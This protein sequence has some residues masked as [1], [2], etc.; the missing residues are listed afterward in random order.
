MRVDNY[1]WLR[2]KTN[3]EVIAY[4]KA[5][6]DYTQ[7]VLDSMKGFQET[8]Y[9]DMLSRIKETDENVPYRKGDYWYYS[10]TETGKQYSIYCRKKGALDSPEEVI[11]DLNELA[12]GHSFLGLSAFAVSPNGKIWRIRSTSPV[13]G[14]TRCSSRILRPARRS[15]TDTN[16]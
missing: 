12:R 11:L 3:P 5:E 2:E 4:L 1:F 9:K 7:S 14:N 15:M 10:R 6:N 16:A 8:L 13:S